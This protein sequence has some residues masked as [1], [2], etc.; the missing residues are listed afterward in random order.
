MKIPDKIKV[1]GI[2]FR[3]RLCRE[4]KMSATTNN[5]FLR[6]NKW[7]EEARN[8][9]LSSFETGPN[10]KIIY[11]TRPRPGRAEDR[12]RA[13]LYNRLPWGRSLF[14]LFHRQNITNKNMMNIPIGILSYVGD[15]KLS[16][17]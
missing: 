1:V 15:P 17:S 16:T 8:V 14:G 9:R 4:H 2:C 12:V 13:E 3:S 5:V 7:P 6:K 11:A 10:P